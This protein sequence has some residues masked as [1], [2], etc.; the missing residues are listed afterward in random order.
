MTVVVTVVIDNVGVGDDEYDDDD[1]GGGGGGDG[2]D[3]YIE[4]END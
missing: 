1:G 4:D 2:D 3:V